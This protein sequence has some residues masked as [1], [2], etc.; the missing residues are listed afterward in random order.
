MTDKPILLVED[1]PDDELLMLR[2]LRK[3]KVNREIVVA[4]DGVEAQR[5]LDKLSPVLVVLD[6][7]LPKVEGLTVLRRIRGDPRIERLPVVVLTS[8]RE[9]RDL[10]E[11][12]AAGAT[13]FIRKPVEFERFVEVVQAVCAYWA[14]LNE[15]PP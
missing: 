11:S 4:R 10:A 8:S 6:L 2:A 3:S 7:K 9:E 1:N 14:S 12:Y 15:P 13:S 5:L